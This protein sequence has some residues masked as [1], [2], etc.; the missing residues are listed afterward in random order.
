[1]PIA[2]AQQFVFVASQ[3]LETL[4]TEKMNH[5]HCLISIHVKWLSVMSKNNENLISSGITTKTT[6]GNVGVAV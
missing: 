4:L 6:N 5:F 1:M 2:Y 3:N